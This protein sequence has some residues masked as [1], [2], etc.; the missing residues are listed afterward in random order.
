MVAAVRVE[1]RDQRRGEAR[2]GDGRRARGGR[3]SLGLRCEG[4]RDGGEAH[5]HHDLEHRKDVLRPRADA[6]PEAVEEQQDEHENERDEKDAVPAAP[7]GRQE[8]PDEILGPDERDAR[9]ARALHERLRPVQAKR[10]RGV[11]AVGH[12]AVV[13]ARARVVGADLRERE[14][15]DEAHE[16]ADSPGEEEE[17]RRPRRARHDRRRPE[18]PDADDEAHDDHRRVER[19]EPRVDLPGFSLHAAPR[20]EGPRA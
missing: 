7:L 4:Q 19:P 20:R 8:K 2:R 18:D 9:R 12:D 11:V 14:R 3:G 15:P 13:A 6:D 10:E 16:A 5:D 17:A 1:D